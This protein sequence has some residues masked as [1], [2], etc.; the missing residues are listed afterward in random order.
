MPVVW[1]WMMGAKNNKNKNNSSR[2]R[3]H[4]IS[5]WFCQ[6]H[7]VISPLFSLSLRP[8]WSNVEWVFTHFLFILAQ[9]RI[10]CQCHNHNILR[11]S[12]QTCPVGFCS[13]FKQRD[14][15]FFLILTCH[16]SLPSLPP[17]PLPPATTPRLLNNPPP[18]FSPTPNRDLSFLILEWLVSLRPHT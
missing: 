9:S 10:N 8:R 17:F 2:E 7:V 5:C 15:Q 1:R 13:V 6:I 12:D 11:G 14:G 16:P 3:P 18:A 4:L